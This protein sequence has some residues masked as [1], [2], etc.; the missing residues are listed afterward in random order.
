[1]EVTRILLDGAKHYPRLVASLPRKVATPRLDSALR[2]LAARRLR[3][4]RILFTKLNRYDSA[5]NGVIKL[6]LWPYPRAARERI[7][8]R[9]CFIRG[10]PYRG[11]DTSV[12]IMRA[13]GIQ[14]LVIKQSAR[15]INARAFACMKNIGYLERVARAPASKP[16]LTFRGRAV[17]GRANCPPRGN[18]SAIAGAAR[19]FHE[20]S[21][22]DESTSIRRHPDNEMRSRAT[23][24]RRPVEGSARNRKRNVL[25]FFLA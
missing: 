9:A 8:P 24:K 21:Q 10:L 19:R 18:R 13:D 5:G 11:S 2:C 23:I 17:A 25:S 1:V 20:K 16:I 3:R 4:R 22:S 7:L 14:H 15:N 12:N 6:A